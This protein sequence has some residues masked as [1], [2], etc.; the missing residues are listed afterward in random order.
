MP[1]ITDRLVRRAIDE[2]AI[3]QTVRSLDVVQLESLVRAVGLEDAGELLAMV[4][5][6]QFVGLVDE[7]LWRG[8]GVGEEFDHARFVT[9]LEV[10]F[11][12]G[13]AL[14]VERLRTLSEETLALA[15]SGQ[16]IVI[17]SDTLGIGL[18][19]ASAH[20][21]E[22]AEKALDAC[23]YLELGNYTLVA[24][25]PLGWDI[26]VAALLALDQ[27]D[28]AMTERILEA[29]ARADTEHL[30]DGGLYELLTA[31]QTLAE[32]ALDDRERRRSARG[33]VSRADAEAFLRTAEQ[34]PVGGP[35]PARDPIT[36]AYFRELDAHAMESSSPASAPDLDALMRELGITPTTHRALPEHTHAE[37][38]AAMRALPPDLLRDREGELAY[39]ANVL[40]ASTRGHS[41]FDA[42]QRVLSTCAR[43]L[44]SLVERGE[45]PEKIVHE[46]GCDVLFRIGTK[47]SPEPW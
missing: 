37:L 2:P 33:F 3:V 8:R 24:R 13:D 34:T 21:A 40:V 14:V 5:P 35:L 27:R 46:V 20:E 36:H 29:C 22:L 28:H 10:L 47:P 4:T 11:E 38:L 25:D 42:A 44:E 19:G 31:A 43:G 1:P 15:F 6:E 41:P 12:G 39:L 30:E 9:W 26:A 18:A 17:D 16:L 32:D 45:K 7:D 23:L